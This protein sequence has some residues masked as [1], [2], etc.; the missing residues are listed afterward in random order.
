[1]SVAASPICT[2]SKQR[3]RS[4][5]SLKGQG[6]G[7][8]DV[9]LQRVA[10]GDPSA[11]Q[12]CIDQFGGL[13]WSLAR[14]LCPNRSDAE[15][16]VQEIFVSVWKSAERY[17]PTMGSEAT[18]IATIARR[19]LIDRARKR[20]RRLGASSLD[21]SYAVAGNAS[22]A[23]GASSSEVPGSSTTLSEDAAIAE[24]AL[25]DLSGDQQRVLRMSIMHGLSHEQISQ[26]T[27]MPLGTVKT[28]IRRGLIRVRKLLEDDTRNTSRS[29]G[30]STPERGSEGGAASGSSSD[31]SSGVQ[32]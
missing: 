29:S 4:V 11:V 28:H 24:R 20:Q 26:A 19:R 32:A 16:A 21:E 9:I 25:R 14:K 2:C 3:L 23:A 8:T 5:S 13:V 30:S 10:G 7:L 1:M 18:F 6:T 22:P 31:T 17:D 27:D 12:D 15:D